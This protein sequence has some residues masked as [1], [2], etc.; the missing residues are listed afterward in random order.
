MGG[1]RGPQKRG[2]SYKNV[3][4]R[5][6]LR[7]RPIFVL[8]C[9]TTYCVCVFISSGYINSLSSHAPTHLVLVARNGYKKYRTK[10]ENSCPH[11]IPSLLTRGNTGSDITKKTNNKMD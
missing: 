3:K 8:I 7:Y 4:I 9:K 6:F 1:A 10:M 2:P 5:R 11:Y